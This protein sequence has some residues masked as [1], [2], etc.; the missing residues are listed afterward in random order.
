MPARSITVTLP[1][2]PLIN[3]SPTIFPWFCVNQRK[4]FLLQDIVVSNCSRNSLSRPCWRI[5]LR[6]FSKSTRI[7]RLLPWRNLQHCSWEFWY[8]YRHVH[9]CI[10]Y[11]CCWMFCWICS[12]KSDSLSIQGRSLWGRIN[13][14]L[15]G[16]Y[17]LTHI[18]RGSLKCLLLF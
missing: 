2:Y 11:L 8:N 5:Q 10:C 3:P 15:A 12:S 14:I 9:W 1:F 4:K 16:L 18:M 6:S 13:I 7:S 17:E